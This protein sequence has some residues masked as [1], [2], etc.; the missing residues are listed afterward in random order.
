MGEIRTRTNSA[1]L[2]PQ[3]SRIVALSS[4]AQPRRES[5]IAPFILY[6]NCLRFF[7]SVTVDTTRN[8]QRRSR[9]P[10]LMTIHGNVPK[11]RLDEQSTVRVEIA[12]VSPPL[13]LGHL[14]RFLPL[15]FP[16]WPTIIGAN[17]LQRLGC[18]HAG[19]EKLAASR[20]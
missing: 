20:Q 18:N 7:A 9:P 4:S 3:S 17:S 2:M 14:L 11:R 5:G 19:R 13:D 8:W 12:A 10:T 6:A 16:R 1:Q 15:Q